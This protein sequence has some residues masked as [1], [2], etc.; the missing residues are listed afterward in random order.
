MLQAAL[1]LTD[2]IQAQTPTVV[3]I[4]LLGF[5]S[6]IDRVLTDPRLFLLVFLSLQSFI[7]FETT[8]LYSRCLIPVGRE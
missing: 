4:P 3:P 1:W 5:H 6:R 7:L 8:F 2:S